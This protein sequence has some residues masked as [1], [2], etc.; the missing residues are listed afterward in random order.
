MRF[1]DSHWRPVDVGE[2]P[3]VTDRPFYRRPLPRG[4][5]RSDRREGVRESSATLGRKNRRTETFS[6]RAGGEQCLLRGDGAG[7][8]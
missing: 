3:R 7:R 8:G 5:G 2:N 6:W 4:G 1:G